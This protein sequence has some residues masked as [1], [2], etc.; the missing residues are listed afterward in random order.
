MLSLMPLDRIRQHAAELLQ[1]NDSLGVSDELEEE[2][3]VV[4]G[5]L[6]WF[7]ESFFTWTNSPACATCGSSNTSSAGMGVP[8][9]EEAQHACSRV[10]LHRCSLCTSVTRFPR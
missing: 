3:L 10:E 1:L 2:D 5:L 7:K 9:A 8:N 4:Q 6:R